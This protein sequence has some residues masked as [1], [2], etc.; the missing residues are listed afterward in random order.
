MLLVLYLDIGF[1]L[2]QSPVGMS[3]DANN[4]SQ[5]AKLCHIQFECL[6]KAIRRQEFNLAHRCQRQSR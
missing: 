1:S 2:T 4:I 5:D 3:C 6:S